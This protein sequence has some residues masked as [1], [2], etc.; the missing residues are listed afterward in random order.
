MAHA[1]PDACPI[2][3][4]NLDLLRAIFE[5]IANN[6]R[7][8]PRRAAVEECW[9]KIGHVC[10]SWRMVLLDMPNLWA[11]DV[12]AFGVLAPF[13]ALLERARNASLHLVFSSDVP[14]YTLI[15]MAHLVPRT[16]ALSRR[17][18]QFDTFPP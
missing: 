7:P 6:D 10:R 11:R 18:W 3:G 8:H 9:M 17:H 12:C 5:L 4:L 1:H 16:I 14:D 15:R 13:D 2:S